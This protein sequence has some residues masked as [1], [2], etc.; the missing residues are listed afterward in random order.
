MKLSPTDPPDDMPSTDHRRDSQRGTMPVGGLLFAAIVAAFGL[1]LLRRARNTR[2]RARTATELATHA[3]RLDD[4]GAGTTVRGPVSVTTPGLPDRTPP[5]EADTTDGD[6]AL[7]AWRVR[8]K[9]SKNRGGSTWRTAESGLA[10]GEFSIAQDWNEIAVDPDA[11]T[12]EGTGLLRGE[13]DPFEASTLSLGDPAFDVRL[14]DLDP[15]NAR[16]ERWGL[17]GEDGIL[18]GFEVTLSSGRRTMTPDRYQATV[19]RDGDELLVRGELDETGDDPVL[20]GTEDVPML[21]AVGDLEE[22]AERLHRQ[23]RRTAIT[24]IAIVGFAVLLGGLTLL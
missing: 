5:A 23:A 7:W 9:R 8:E 3:E 16:L 22:R 14:G 6:P 15:I 1:V 10:V 24:G 4:D 21:A 11:L 18:S 2:H 13:S 12:D 17:T 20:R 19:V